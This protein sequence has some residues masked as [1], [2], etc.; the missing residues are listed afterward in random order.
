MDGQ[1]WAAALLV[2]IAALYLA[3]RWL[4]RFARKRLGVPAAPACGACHDCAGC[5]KRP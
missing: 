5:D 2:L 4:P 1:S 3:W